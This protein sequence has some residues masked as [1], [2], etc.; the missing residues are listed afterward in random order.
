MNPRA[1][2]T[3]GLPTFSQWIHTGCFYGI[4]SVGVRL[5]GGTSELNSFKRF[6]FRH[7]EEK[8]NYS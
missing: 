6:F 2:E 7:F 8:L 3:P 1:F 5:N 4:F